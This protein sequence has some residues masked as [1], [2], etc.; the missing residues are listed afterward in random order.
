VSAIAQDPARQDAVPFDHHRLDRLLVD[1][2]I[3]VVL[4]TSPF[5][6]RYLLGGH[7]FWIKKFTGAMA[8][9]QWLPVVGYVRDDPGAAFYYGQAAEIWQHQVSPVWIADT[10]TTTTTFADAIEKTVAA[11]RER[12]LASA[13]IGI[14]GHFLP[15]AAAR[16]LREALP[17]ATFV[18][19]NSVLEH[20]RAIKTPRELEVLRRVTDGVVDAM[21][22][23]FATAPEGATTVEI[24][25]RL[26]EE[27]V[28]LGLDFDFCLVTA[29]TSVTR[30]PS[31]DRWEAGGMLSLDSG[32]FLDGFL[33][34]VARMGSRGEPG[35]EQT[36]ILAEIIA[37]HDAIFRRTRA[38]MRGRALVETGRTALA[39]SAHASEMFLDIHG[40]GLVTHEAPRLMP[41]GSITPDHVEMP[42]EPS[43]VLSVET[44][45]QRPGFGFIKIEDTVVVTDDGAEVL[46][47][48]GRGW[49]VA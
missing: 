38:G 4:A 42:L 19:A 25:H 48:R 43:M 12:D 37:I 26:A 45:F 21:L 28:R 18:E 40:L 3:D 22:A 10:E 17:G 24:S 27:Q 16:Q 32:A 6:V 11:L 47:D 8:L 13:T 23:V 14:E 49:N 30:A 29:G 20:Q 44:T 36:Q 35:T 5:N 33:G 31:A 7:Y 39:E 41:L 2:G 46:G 34:D 15:E 1:A 9:T